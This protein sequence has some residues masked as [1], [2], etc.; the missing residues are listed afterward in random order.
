MQGRGCVC[1]IQRC[2]IRNAKPSNCA[3]NPICCWLRCR[4]RSTRG[5]WCCPLARSKVSRPNRWLSPSQP[6]ISASFRALCCFLGSDFGIPAS[7]PPISATS[8]PS[9]TTAQV[10]KPHTRVPAARYVYVSV[11]ICE[12]ALLI[13]RDSSVRIGQSAQPSLSPGT[14]LCGLGGH[15]HSRS[16]YEYP[17]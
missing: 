8:A 4:W 15:T 17:T 16:H 7:R 6:N 1:L 2:C 3:S 13:S 5:W 9:A 11:C 14:P 12:C 10:H